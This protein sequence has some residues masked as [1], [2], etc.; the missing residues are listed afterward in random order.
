M[1]HVIGS[2]LD[3]RNLTRDEWNRYVATDEPYDPACHAQQPGG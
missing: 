2:L 1:Q 3:G